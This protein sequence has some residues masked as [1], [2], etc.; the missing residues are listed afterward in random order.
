MKI[1]H[2]SADDVVLDDEDVRSHQTLASNASKVNLSTE[3]TMV[4]KKT[5]NFKPWTPNVS[6]SFTPSSQSWSFESSEEA[7]IYFIHPGK[8]GGKSLY[9]HLG[10]H[11]KTRYLSCLMKGL[12][13]MRCLPTKQKGTMLRQLVQGHLHVA[14]PRYKP[15]QREWLRNHSNLLLFT[16]REPL[17]R[18]VSAFNYHFN[19]QFQ[20]QAPLARKEYDHDDAKAEVYLDC[21]PTVEDLAL[22]LHPRN[23]TVSLYCRDLAQKLLSGQLQSRE[24]LHFKWNYGKYASMVWE[25]RQKSIAVIRTE[26]LWDDVANLEERFGGN[27]ELFRS[28]EVE[29]FTHGSEAFVLQSGVS[30]R[31]ALG[32]CCGLHKDLQVYQ[33]LIAAAVNLKK[34]EKATTLRILHKRC[35]I[36][37]VDTLH[38]FEESANWE[39]GSWFNRHCA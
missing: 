16:V 33:D 32:L 21:F 10:I 30:A 14:S 28:G 31:G 3:H 22:S 15:E 26:S 9:R 12:P 6:N 37:E 20:G 7:R 23:S 29:K 5:S 18:I 2:S 8:S 38:N 1:F 34:N 36:S 11:G 27:S 35:D 39:W 13:A 24:F 19:E 4:G 25:D 17:D